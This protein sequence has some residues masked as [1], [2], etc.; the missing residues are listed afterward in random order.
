M[1]LQHKNQYYIMT[2][3]AKRQNSSNRQHVTEYIT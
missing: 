2:V 1:P 3:H